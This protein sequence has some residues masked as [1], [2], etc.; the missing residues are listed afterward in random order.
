MTKTKKALLAVLCTAF[1]LMLTFLCVELPRNVAHA[2]EAEELA[3]IEIPLEMET[4]NSEVEPTGLITK[5]SIALRSENGNIIAVAKNEFTLFPAT[6]S[7][8]VFLYTST[9][10]EENYKNMTEVAHNYIYDLDQFHSLEAGYPINGEQRFWRG[11][12]HFK[13]DDSDWQ[14]LL[15]DIV[16]YDANG[17]FIYNY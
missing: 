11:R 14:E 7:L 6:I 5:I 2:A 3:E 8:H 16:L 9:E 15:S 1:A 12:V 4:K 17:N 13:M 10:L